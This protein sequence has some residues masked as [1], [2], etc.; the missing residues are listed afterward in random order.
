MTKASTTRT[1]PNRTVSSVVRPLATNVARLPL[2]AIWIG[3]AAP[4][5]DTAYANEPRN[6][7]SAGLTGRGETFIC[8]LRDTRGQDLIYNFESLAVGALSETSITRGTATTTRAQRPIWATRVEQT[9]PRTYLFIATY[10]LDPRFSIVMPNR[11]R[12]IGEDDMDGNEA[13]LVRSGSAE[14]IAKGTCHIVV[15]SATR[16]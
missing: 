1:K 8:A 4:A 15:D 12:P 3:L 9:G 5:L 16:P 13:A 6:T 2:L 7:F 14:P 10:G 11:T